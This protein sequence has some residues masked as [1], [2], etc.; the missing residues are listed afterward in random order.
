M[1]A[2]VYTRPGALSRRLRLR[3][4]HDLRKQLEAGQSRRKPSV[5]NDVNERLANLLGGNSLLQRAAEVRAQLPLPSE[6]GGNGDRQEPT[7][8]EI[9]TGSRPHIPETGRAQ[10]L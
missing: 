8:F 5:G 9:E 3:R 10:Q 1:V 6:R 7:R 4:L 2:Y